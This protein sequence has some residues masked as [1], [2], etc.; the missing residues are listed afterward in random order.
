MGDS[1]TI[2]E[3]GCLC[4]R[5]RFTASGEPVA[6]AHC[7]CPSCRR[8]T[9]AAVVAWAMY[10]QGQV[11]FNAQA[12]SSGAQA[13]RSSAQALSHYESSPGAVRGFCTNCGTSL[14]FE[15]ELIDGLIDLTIASFDDPTGLAP[16]IHIWHRHRLPWVAVEDG[17]TIFEELPAAPPG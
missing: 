1:S 13:L 4:G 7:H 16:D 11:R 12:P 2:R 10:P 17:A 6:K 8:A 3:G 15:G 14:C 5:V 9:G